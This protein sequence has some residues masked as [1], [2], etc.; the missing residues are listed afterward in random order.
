MALTIGFSNL[1]AMDMAGTRAFGIP[2]G[3]IAGTVSWEWVLWRFFCGLGMGKV[4]RWDRRPKSCLPTHLDRDPRGVR[5]IYSVCVLF[6]LLTRL[7]AD[8]E[9]D[10]TRPKSIAGRLLGGLRNRCLDRLRWGG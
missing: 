4:K 7:G 3:E 9:P 1:K 6:G 5:T 2:R 8:P 10:G